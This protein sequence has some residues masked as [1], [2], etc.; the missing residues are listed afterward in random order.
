MREVKLFLML[1][2]LVIALSGVVISEVETSGSTFQTEYSPGE[3]VKGFLN[4]TLTEHDYNSLITSSED[5]SMLLSDFLKANANAG[6]FSF[7]CTPG[8]C[9]SNYEVSGGST[10]LVVPL[11]IGTP[12]TVG[13][14]L[15]GTNVNLNSVNFTVTSDFGQ[16]VGRPLE[17]VFFEE[18]EWGYESFSEE[19]RDKDWG[20]Y[21]PTGAV[22]SNSLVGVTAHCERI[23]SHETNSFFVGAR[24]DEG[25]TKDLLMSV[26]GSDGSSYG[27]C[28]FDPN[29][30]DEDGDG[31]II[32]IDSGTY[33]SGYYDVC[34]TST[35]NFNTGYKIFND[36]TGDSC[37]YFAN[38]FAN[39]EN[40]TVDYSIFLSGAKFANAT[41][42]GDL[43]L[44]FLDLADAADR[45]IN[46]RYGRD[47]TLGCVLP[48][49]FDGFI[50]NLE[51]KDVKIEYSSTGNFENNN[52]Y[53]LD[54]L[55]AL[56]DSTG[57]VNLG[58][59]LFN[60]T[61]TGEYSIFIGE[62]EIIKRNVKILPA[63][64]VRAVTP[65]NPP[66]GVPVSFFADVTNA[67][68]NASLTYNWD[69]GDGVKVTT[70]T[71]NVTHVYPEVLLYIL[72]IEVKN[73]D[74]L[75]SFKTFNI[76]T[77][78]PRA[79]INFTLLEKRNTFDKFVKDLRLDSS[80]YNEALE[81]SINVQDYS[82]A[83]D[84]L[85]K[86]ES[87]AFTN[88]DYLSV[89]KELYDLDIPVV[90]G[91]Q[92]ESGSSFLTDLGDVHPEVV[93]SFA[94]GISGD[95]L[96]GYPEEVLRWQDAN[97][98]SSINSNSY[99]VNF[100]SGDSNGVFR[101]YE[102]TLNS[103]SDTPSYLVIN[104]PFSE[105]F[106]RNEI[107]AEKEGTSTVIVIDPLEQEKKFEFYVK[108]SE[109]VSFFV[110]PRLSEI[111]LPEEIDPTCNYN[112]ICEE[113][114]EDYNT[115]RADCKPVGRAIFY[116][117]L[118]VFFVLILYSILQF[119]YKVHYENF[120][121]GGNRKELFNLLS[122]VTN[123]RSRGVSEVHIRGGLKKQGWS[124]ER[125]NYVLKK[126]RGERTGMLE[127]LP[128]EKI[129]S[130][131][132]NRQAAKKVALEGQQQN[133]AKI[134]KYPFRTR[135]R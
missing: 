45:I 19:Y 12:N 50:Q 7:T 72:G 51:I 26:Y 3:T 58:L 82:D 125:V 114:T 23:F 93:A 112:N 31:C 70:N 88:D 130:Y 36:S 1:L 61:S 106:F 122:F 76:H 89:A 77:L 5:E 35:D 17:A 87:A 28:E 94:G 60:V 59:T 34:V 22:Y 126:S 98:E 53:D 33:P 16:Q 69:F 99:L 74:G 63:P 14:V 44:N 43:G 64:I 56:I 65:L 40:S 104:K 131:F 92:I 116:T 127:I 67:P 46:D 83:L 18:L 101:T 54:E 37:G 68:K 52:V 13:F 121:F 132:R 20:C 55:P 118:S 91:K 105:V 24:V 75:G 109:P 41:F 95:D 107:S 85:V 129:A 124:L 113:E 79:A 102:V 57:T 39:V 123:A 8:D 97:I 78:N 15:Y 6:N 29:S 49:K 120:L 47:C 62:D 30:E 96:E 84:A 66:A 134:N 100:W 108:D 10:S 4:L 111:I 86:L 117:I 2:A 27:D 90:L 32:P 21:E 115:C 73:S 38:G 80:W 135:F 110:S 103:F 48:I 42:L 11:T 71:P 119:W 25:D 133:E 81:S 128:F 9:S